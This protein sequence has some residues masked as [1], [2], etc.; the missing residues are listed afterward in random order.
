[1]HT[2]LEP[3]ALPVVGGTQLLWPYPRFA[4]AAAAAKKALA[5]GPSPGFEDTTPVASDRVATA[6]ANDD[7]QYKHEANPKA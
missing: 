2:G 5:P 4:Y 3:F 1:M 6:L 7:R